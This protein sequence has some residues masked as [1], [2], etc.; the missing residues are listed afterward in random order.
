[1][2]LGSRATGSFP[3]LVDFSID[4]RLEKSVKGPDYAIDATLVWGYI[5]G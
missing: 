5:W 3:E 2:G 4:G 1:L